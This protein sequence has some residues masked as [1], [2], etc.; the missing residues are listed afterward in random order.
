MEKW[1]IGMCNVKRV[2]ADLIPIDQRKSPIRV[3]QSGQLFIGTH[4]EALTVAMRV[5]SEDCS[6]TRVYR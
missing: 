6:P 3:P 4:N 2:N 5:R 1:Q